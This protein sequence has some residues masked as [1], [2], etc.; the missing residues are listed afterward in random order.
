MKPARPKLSLF[1]LLWLTFFPTIANAALRVVIAPVRG[2]AKYPLIMNGLRQVLMTDLSRSGQISV[3]T[4]NIPEKQLYTATI[5]S[6]ATAIPADAVISL[7][8]VQRVSDFTVS[9][10]VNQLPSGYSMGA[11]EFQGT[12]GEIKSLQ[13]RLFNSSI[14][15][16]RANVPANIRG[17]V[18]K[19]H[20]KV[21]SAVQSMGEA[22]IAL[23]DKKYLEAI[24][25]FSRARA[26]DKTFKAP[27][28][29][30]ENLA[31]RLVDKINRPE[32]LGRAYSRMG[33]SRRSLDQ[34]DQALKRDPKN[35]YAL[36]GK[37]DLMLQMNRPAKA[38]V[39]F[40]A[41]NAVDPKDAMAAV[42]QAR[43]Y[44]ALGRKT[45]AL[46]AYERA[47][48]LGATNPEIYETLGSMYWA[49]RRTRASAR[50][51]Q[52]AGELSER[53]VNFRAAQRNYKRANQIAPSVASLERGAE[54]YLASDQA[55]IA[56]T[57][58]TKALVL[59]PNNDNVL[60]RLGYAYYRNG[61]P[62]VAIR[63]LKKSY[64][65]N[66]RNYDANFYL[67][68]VYSKR[69]KA[70]KTAI[71]FFEN[72]ARIRPDSKDPAYYLANLYVLDSRPTAAIGILEKLA[73]VHSRDPQ[74]HKELGDAYFASENYPGAETSYSR[75]VNLSPDY[76]EAHEGL[77]RLYIER[78]DQEK[79]FLAIDRVYAIDATNNIFVNGGGILLEKLT[80]KT[81]IEFVLRFPKMAS[82]LSGEVPINQVGV[83]PLTTRKDTLGRI[84][85]LLSPYRVNLRRIRLDLEIALYAQYRVI[86]GRRMG[87]LASAQ[88]P[89]EDFES[90]S[91][92]EAVVGPLTLDGL[93]G[94]EIL[95]YKTTKTS[96]QVKLNIFL[97]SL[98]DRGLHGIS[99]TAALPEIS[100]AKGEI[101]TWNYQ[102]FVIYALIFLLI[103]GPYTYFSVYRSRVRGW[104]N[105]RVVINYDP[106]L[107]SFLTLKL[108][109]RQEKV[110]DTTKLFVRDKD[111]SK[112]KK[113]RELLK[114][115]GAWV[116]QMVGKVTQFERVPAKT[117]YCYL[118]GTIEDA[119]ARSTVGNY[120]MVQ[121][122]KVQK[123]QT[124]E[125]I[126]QLEKEEAFVTVFIRKGDDDIAG[127]EIYVAGDPDV[128]YSRGEQGA[129]VYLGKGKHKVTVKH[130][131]KSF[132]HEIDVYDLNDKV[133]NIDILSVEEIEETATEGGNLKE[134]AADFEQQGRMED[135][136]RL[137]EKAGANEEAGNARAQHMIEE[138][139][140]EGAAQEFVRAR[141][142]IK[143]AELY[144]QTGD[145]KKTNTMY[146]LYYFNEGNF[147]TATKYL[148]EAEAYGTLAKVY[149]KLGD[150]KN[151][152]LS[153][154][155]DYLSKG[156]KIEAAQAFMKA[157]SNADAA[158]LYSDLKDYQKAAVLYAKDGN[159][160]VAAELFAQA[161]DSR[162]AATAFE[163]AGQVEAAIPLYQELGETKKVLELFVRAERFLEA[164]ALYQK[165]GSIDDSIALCQ[166]VTSLHSDYPHTQL[167]LGQMF[168]E[169]GM[170]DLAIKT[171]NE[172]M[173]NRPNSLDTDALYNYGAVLE[174]CEDYVKALEIFEILLKKDFHHKDVSLRVTEL[175]EKAETQ[176]AKATVELSGET[177]S[178]APAKKDERYEVLEEIGRGAMGI[179]YKA[180]DKMLERVVAFKTLPQTL[181]NDPE[182][183]DSLVKEAQTAAK[184]NHPN[185]VTVFDVGEEG[186]NYFIAMEYVEGKTLAQILQQVKKV[187]LANFLHIAKPL[188]E[189]I[190]YAHEQRVIHRDVKPSNILLLPS[191]TVKLMDFGLAKVLQDMAIDKTMLRGTPLYMSPEQ[192]LGKD[193]DHRTDIYSLGILFYEM[194]A[195]TPPFVTGDIMYA[196][197]HTAPPPLTEEMTDAPSP[198]RDTIMK[199]LSKDKTERPENAQ[200]FLTGLLKNA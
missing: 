162:R 17:E 90:D 155:R 59:E 91:Y 50:A 118:Y 171:F 126:F 67:G 144:T 167:L 197:L 82:A 174:R 102:A 191:R 185:I 133:V 88:L 122:F 8:F 169:K 156:Q 40:R 48:D 27:T 186:G 107:E 62:D 41:A 98:A 173:V 119:V 179:V 110:K 74:I 80:K 172:A 56:I 32:L 99:Q 6:G 29:Q 43:A 58:L 11:R 109:T 124:R 16:L 195:G 178:G 85:E 106:K 188:C 117:Y 34:Y 159:Y 175:K 158:E 37:G 89:R 76:K 75:A 79:A 130:E 131:G 33:K 53:A 64:D 28:Y 57:L 10:R 145:T 87:D 63:K 189:V 183:L 46:A 147:D 69:E 193:I 199:A 132:G 60:A 112:K 113:Y 181:K 177:I 105:V 13:D 103:F 38:L 141:D 151:A 157:G 78:G 153:T 83:V 149:A 49:K 26:S 128:K 45:Q 18:A 120:Y 143:A 137:Y 66:S 5:E 71:R 135:A 138:G 81:L 92:V 51:Y 154:A 52:T 21:L 14:D 86:T 97:Y 192:V 19:T 2:N 39:L 96:D 187:N 180:R 200:E 170:N 161:G 152:L 12:Y 116:R 70:R 31:P 95:D 190:G 36:V 150:E 164:A 101:L 168:A 123:N 68:V 163:K 1:L 125:V 136:A 22:E 94:F 25:S 72:A 115:K 194:L 93:F 139:N 129:F 35:T 108:S 104:G 114:Q 54:A 184:L 4:E 127:A 100:Y 84:K 176:K 77:A 55:A 9:V 73:Q 30:L 44:Q 182:A 196:H 23:K 160:E 42:G 121:Q 134:V 166:K 61:Q 198:I 165:E 15:L 47:R 146:G 148:T 111:K 142:F 7:N 140:L 3:V 24:D 20:S 65:L